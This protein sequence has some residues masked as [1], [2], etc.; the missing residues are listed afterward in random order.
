MH[1]FI[2][3]FPVLSAQRAKALEASVVS[4]MDH[5]WLIMQRAGLGIAQQVISDYQELRP[6]PE[7]VR[8]I[9]IAG[10]GHNGGD[11]L[12]ACKKLL[13]D[14]PR[15]TI[16]LLKTCKSESMKPLALY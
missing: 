15:A 14:L 2:R 7:Y 12:L 1:S 4:S 8:I 13:S 9:V 6:L 3:S 5:E 16:T 11:A 10:K